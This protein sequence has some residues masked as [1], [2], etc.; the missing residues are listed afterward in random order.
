MGTFLVLVGLIGICWGLVGLIRSFFKKGNKKRNFI[1]IGTAFIL[2]IFG[3]SISPTSHSDSSKVSTQSE[4]KI[5]TKRTS[6][7]SSEEQLKQ[8][9]EHKEKEK[10]KLDA[11]RKKQEEE[12]QKLEAERKKQEEE[13]QKLEAERK[14]QEEEKQKLEAER[15]KQEEEKQ[16]I[17][18]ERKAQEERQKQAENEATTALSQAEAH[19]TRENYNSAATLIQ[20]IPNG[21]QHLSA[22]LATVDATIKAN[23]AAEAERQR[24]AAA[25]QEQANQVA[26]AQTP[27]QNNEQTVYI[28]PDHGTKYHLNPN[29]SGL[30]NANSVVAIS[31]QEAQARGYTLCKRG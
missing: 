17:E 26:A 10:R 1:I 5:E 3:A 24:Q 18:A 13:K 23:E 25:A 11:E 29:C 2:M 16:K 14:K 4:K 21:N 15:K 31:L 27:Q 30:N 7:T 20:A 8:K 28:A 9:A 12:K 19:P 6:S 22:R